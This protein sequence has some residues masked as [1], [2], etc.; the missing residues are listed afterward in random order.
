MKWRKKKQDN[1]EKQDILFDVDE[2]MEMDDEF[3]MAEEID[4]YSTCTGLNAPR[5]SS[6]CF[7]AVMLPTIT[8]LN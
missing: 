5:C 4:G 2:F 7:A 3:L 8:T 1:L 6:D